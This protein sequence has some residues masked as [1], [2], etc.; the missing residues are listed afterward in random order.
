MNLR[1]ALLCSVVTVAFAAD[2]PYLGKWKQ[3]VAKSDFGDTTLTYESLPGGEWQAS[4]F[5]IS[6]KFKMDGKEYPDGMGGTT[7]WKP[8]NSTTWDI[9]D[10]TNG[11]VTTTVALKLSADGKTLDETDKINKA[12]GG[13]MESST[14]YRRISGGPGLAGKWKTQKISGAA[15]TMEFTSSAP[16]Q[17]TYRDMD[18]GMTCPSKL[19]GKDYPCSGPTAGPGFTLSIRKASPASLDFVVK[20][21][22]KPMFKGT[23]AVSADGKSMTEIG[24]GASGADTFKI[25]WD[26]M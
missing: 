6:Y 20:K 24:N 17:L 13:T 4:F 26:R 5:G 8:I 25:V 23:Y 10:K 1:F 7:A 22:G 9:V 16:D 12:D 19:D 18:M 14:T 2:M 3:N 21:D 11:K 15:A